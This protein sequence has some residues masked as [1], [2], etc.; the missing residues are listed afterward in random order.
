MEI[1]IESLQKPVALRLF[2]GPQATGWTAGLPFNYNEFIWDNA[3]K[4][5]TWEKTTD[6]T[7]LYVMVRN[8]FCEDRSYSL[9]AQEEA[10]LDPLIIAAI[11]CGMCLLVVTVLA[12]VYACNGRTQTTKKSAPSPIEIPE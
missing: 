9:W 6:D 12:V 7:E 3:S 2:F 11:V 10:K 8:D 1:H 5:Q 4:S